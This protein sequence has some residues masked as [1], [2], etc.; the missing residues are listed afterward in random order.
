MVSDADEQGCSPHR[1]HRANP[2]IG[3]PLQADLR[4][5]ARVHSPTE[6]FLLPDTFYSD[7]I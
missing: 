1:E 4:R 7:M 6:T 5:G 2:L 3:N